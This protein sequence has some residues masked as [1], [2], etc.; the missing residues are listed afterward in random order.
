MI[1]LKRILIVF[2]L[3]G[4]AEKGYTQDAP[5][6]IIVEGNQEFCGSAPMNIVTSVTISDPDAGDNTLEN[7]FIQISQGY[8][9]NQDLLVLS[10]TH[11]NITPS[12]SVQEGKLTL[13]GPAS[14]SEFT[15]AITSVTFQT[16]QTNFTEDKTFSINLG[17]ANYLPSSGH[18][19]QYIPDPGIRWSE[20]RSNAEDLTYFGLQGYLATLT[21]IEEALFAGEQSPGVGWIG[22]SDAEVEGN[23]RWVTGPEANQLFWIGAVGGASPDGQFSYWNTGEPNNFG[24]EH[25]AHITDPS[26]G[27]LGAWNDLPNEGDT[28]PS[29]PYHPQG[30]FVEFGGMPG[31][32]DVSLSGSTTIVTP[33]MTFDDIV[34]CNEGQANLNVTSNTNTLLW[35]ETPSSTIPINSGFN[36]SAFLTETTTYWVLPLF[37][38]CSGGSRTRAM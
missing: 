19:Y 29:S 27:D 14:F 3:F 16:T 20:A 10:G 32:P 23:W 31:D 36:Y 4:F 12:W 17:D 18:Y 37:D 6:S 28:D 1:T 8:T 7:V 35:Y 24:E 33:K 38:G 21:T 2:L 26:V 25:Y 15:D 5:S 30:Y 22:G 13:E 11:P 9:A 34:I